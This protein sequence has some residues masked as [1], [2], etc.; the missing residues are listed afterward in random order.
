MHGVNNVRREQ[1]PLV[2]TAELREHISNDRMEAGN[3]QGPC[4]RLQN[5]KP[6]PSSEGLKFDQELPGYERPSGTSVAPV[7]P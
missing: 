4:R 1:D 3:D 5:K 6:Q 2:T 7:K